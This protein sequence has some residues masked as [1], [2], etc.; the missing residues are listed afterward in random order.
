M[1]K[2]V[3]V[4]G[5]PSIQGMIGSIPEQS[6][7]GACPKCDAPPRYALDASVGL[8]R[9]AQDENEANY[10]YEADSSLESS[11]KGVSFNDLPVIICGNCLSYFVAKPVRNIA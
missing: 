3:I 9:I 6:E 11:W 2:I 5:R 10:A 8:Q 7:T 4:D 1:L